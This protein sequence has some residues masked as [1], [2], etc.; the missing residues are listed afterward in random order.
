MRV[1]IPMVVYKPQVS[2]KP[3]LAVL[4]VL[5]TLPARMRRPRSGAGIKRCLR[6][7]RFEREEARPRQRTPTRYEME[8]PES[9]TGMAMS[10]S[11]DE[12][13]QQRETVTARGVL[14]H[15][16]HARADTAKAVFRQGRPRTYQ[17]RQSRVRTRRRQ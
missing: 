3:R 7:I 16:Q 12:N 15:V 2:N 14:R 8:S 9:E 11:E 13:A 17:G 1:S 5:A 4:R 6:L 10:C